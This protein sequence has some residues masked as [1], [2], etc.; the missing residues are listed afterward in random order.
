L[1]SEAREIETCFDF[2]AS[3]DIKSANADL[4]FLV[5]ASAARRRKEEPENHIAFEPFFEIKQEFFRFIEMFLQLLG[6]LIEI[7]AGFDE[8]EQDNGK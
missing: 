3:A 5:V 6:N 2:R 1:S 8:I 7:F 4:F